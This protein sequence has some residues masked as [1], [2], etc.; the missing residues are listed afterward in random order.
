MIRSFG[1]DFGATDAT[2]GSKALVQVAVAGF[3]ATVLFRSSLFLVR[4]GD[5][6][7][8]VGPNL[9]LQVIL[10]AADRGV[11][12][13]RAAARAKDVAKAMKDISFAKAYVALPAHCLALMQNLPKDD[14]DELA[15]VI[16]ALSL[17]AEMDEHT[18]TLNLGLALMNVVGVGVLEA[19][20]Q[21]LGERIKN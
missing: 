18:K 16:T 14:Q 9:V 1:W 4:I 10:G 5:Q 20:V 3:S 7:V 15:K 2:E 11:D 12:R 17:S 6:D 8:G 19:A 21:S 13:V